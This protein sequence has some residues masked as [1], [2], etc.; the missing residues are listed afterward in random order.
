ML[1]LAAV[2]TAAVLLAGGSS[3]NE[4]RGR[5]LDGS[6][7]EDSE[8]CAPSQLVRDFG[9]SRMPEVDERPPSGDL[10]FGPKTVG[11]ISNGWRILPVG[12]SYGF[13]FW[14]QNYTGRT[15]LRWTF[16][17]RIHAVSDD[18]E[19]V[20]LVDRERRRV[21][22][23]RAAD[24]VKLLLGPLKRAGFYRY[25]FEILDEDKKV[26]GSY[27]EHIKIFQRE[28]WKPRLGLDRQIY[29]PGQ[30]VLSRPEN[31]GTETIL[32]GAAYRVQQFKRGNWQASPRDPIVGF[33]AWLGFVGPGRAGR[34]SAFNIPRDFPPGRYRIVKEVGRS[35]LWPSRGRSYHL[36]A[37]FEVVRSQAAG[38]G[39]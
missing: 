36:A 5:M 33:Q 30:R 6:T 27:S 18:G 39:E 17:A 2:A 16:H 9:L 38:G 23:I 26:L 3:P 11:L 19:P 25:E 31:L 37:P 22:S 32:F 28:F 4:E 10:P 12:S 21:R 24:E 1:T 8:F 34:C 20:R 14:S 35:P 13:E 15:P 7:F 29:R